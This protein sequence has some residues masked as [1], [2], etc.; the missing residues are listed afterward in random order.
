M[1]RTSTY[2]AFADGPIPSA[3]VDDSRSV[4]PCD[5]IQKVGISIFRENFDENSSEPSTFFLLL[6]GPEHARTLAD[7]RAIG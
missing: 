3:M 4:M 2:C 7:W 6:E 5:K 1:V